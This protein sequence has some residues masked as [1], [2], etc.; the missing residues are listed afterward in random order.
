MSVV[1]SLPLQHLQPCVHW[2]QPL[3]QFGSLFPVFQP[4]VPLRWTEN[5]EVM[6]EILA[7]LKSCQ[8]WVLPPA[9]FIGSLIPVT[10]VDLEILKMV[11][12]I[13]AAAPRSTFTINTSP[14]SL[15]NA[16]YLERLKSF[17]CHREIH[18]GR[19][20]LEVTEDPIDVLTEIKVMDRIDELRE[21]G[22]RVA[23][24]DFGSG[25]NGIARL[26]AGH[27]DIV[28]MAPAMD[29]CSARGR[30][31]IE[32]VLNMI[33]GLAKAGEGDMQLVIEGVETLQHLDQATY[34]NAHYGQGYIISPPVGE[35]VDDRKLNERLKWLFA[36]NVR[37]C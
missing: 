16:Q 18:T 32:N 30:V 24:D 28:K 4:I 2:E 31:I 25:G 36:E 3:G 7:R 6:Y 20:V 19:L 1:H 14:A 5:D 8:G 15:C 22:V 26:A 34:I 27:F 29:I 37:C 23:L 12:E 11:P 13:Q 17:F 35:I 33:E 10:T 21:M 9:E